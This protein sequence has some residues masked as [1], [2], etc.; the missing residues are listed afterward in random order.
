M[1]VIRI[2]AFGPLRLWLNEEPVPDKAWPTQ[3]SRQL[4]EIL[5]IHYGRLVPADKL[6]DYLWPALSVKQAR[7]N[8]WVTMS[9]TR[10]VLEPDL[11][12]RAASTFILKQGDGYLLQPNQDCWIDIKR[13]Q[14]SIDQAQHA[15]SSSEAIEHLQHAVDLY[16]G[17]LFTH[18][19]YAEWAIQPRRQLR[20]AFISTAL[21]LASAYAHQGRFRRSIK[22]CRYCLGF[23][24]SRESIY[25]ALM[26]YLYCAGEKSE[27]L[28]VYEAARQMLLA[29]IGVEPAT[30]TKILLQQIQNQQVIGV[31]IEGQYPPH[32]D[33][34]SALFLL[35]QMPLVGRTQELKQLVDLI[36]E[37]KN[38]RCQIGLVTGESGIGKSR[39]LQ[40]ANEKARQG[41]LATLR[42]S[43]HQIEQDLLYEPLIDLV[44]QMHQAWPELI[45]SLAPVWL[46][47]LGFLLPD[48]IKSPRQ[49]VNFYD[50]VTET[51]QGHLF[52][53]VLQYLSLAAHESGLI[54]TVED[55]QWA[56]E[57]TLLFLHYLGRRIN[58]SGILL[59]LSYRQEERDA[60]PQLANFLHQLQR[61]PM[62]TTVHLD[63][64]TA[65]DIDRLLAAQP[66]LPENWANWLYAE[67]LGNPFF[68]VSI[69]QSL[70]EQ[71]LIPDE[72]TG[73][74]QPPSGISLPHSIKESIKERLRSLETKAC[75][76]MEWLAVYGRPLD[77]Q[78]LKAISD[79][80]DDTLLEIVDHLLQRNFLLEGADG[81]EFSHHKVAEF[82]Y[83]ELSDIRRIVSHQKIGQ[84]L[85][86]IGKD[87]P[88]LLA[89]HFVRAGNTEL[90][91]KYWLQAGQAALGG[92][93]LRLAASHFSSVLELADKPG[94][95]LEA[96]I[97]LGYALTILD[98]VDEAAS[99]LQAGITLAEKVHD[100]W[101]IARLGF[102]YAQLVSRQHPSDAA[103]VEIRHALLLAEKVQDEN[104]IARLLLLLSVAQASNGML[105]DALDSVIQ[106][107]TF[108]QKVKDQHLEAQTLNE[109]GFIYTQLGEFKKGIDAV[110]KALAL[111]ASSPDPGISTY[112]WNILGRGLGGFGKYQQ[113]LE[114]FETCRQQAAEL[115]DR[116]FLAQVPN[117]LGWLYR[118][119]YAFER[120]EQ[121]DQ[122]SVDLAIKYDKS[123]IEISARLNLC[124]DWLG[125][126]RWDDSYVALQHI[127]KQIAAGQFGFHQ[128]RWRLRLLH[129]WGHYYLQTGHPELALSNSENLWDL[130][131]EVNAQKYMCL[132]QQLQG[133]AL[134]EL[135]RLDEAAIALQRAVQLAISI[136]YRPVLWE[137][138][139]QLAT[140]QPEISQEILAK[141][142]NLVRE[143]ASQLLDSD[144]QQGFLN[145]ST[146]QAL[147]AANNPT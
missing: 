125:M 127:E 98:E 2:Q 140:I 134:I 59:L 74:T 142:R 116:F 103:A 117:M 32:D 100:A 147:F 9:Q 107:R 144:L 135:V 18:D 133:D 65:R 88:A 72:P 8:L 10:R 3:K 15:A 91:I 49:A 52:Q 30:Q 39:L 29:E 97:G 122:E 87:S 120:A 25:R 132:S 6:M 4:F 54:I 78:T 42:I 110:E 5:L 121:C 109:L 131:Q 50:D 73:Q 141:G 94:S 79:Q 93:A 67:T 136:A 146:I 105:P 14:E 123:P 64:L 31:D 56:D 22:I 119:L 41:G 96:Y 85:K 95:R 34:R 43:C 80:E 63:R 24:P 99:V 82:L 11:A 19:P 55:I 70:V 83:A 13:F 113:A 92:Y 35:S 71:Q 16:L 38:G 36:H 48:L 112:S 12:P 104:L 75:V 53:A 86:R 60:D 145:S 90:A 114:A 77:F 66:T 40:E 76:I 58:A 128:W 129:I 21:E 51:R 115:E 130:A 37:L 45:K 69:L 33:T 7:N 101:R 62:T 17:D 44:R 138:G 118:E 57:G 26:L 108:S 23:D 139:C 27:A 20:E 137:A 124:L 84:T 89:Y 28:H 143:T 1:G 111:Q 102:R 106:A 61:L 46:V 81:F 126:K 68:I 47:E